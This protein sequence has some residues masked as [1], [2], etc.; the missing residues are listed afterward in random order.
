MTGRIDCFHSLKA[1][2]GGGV[3]F[4]DGNKIF[5]LS[6]GKIGKFIN[7]VIEDVYYVSGLK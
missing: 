6:V 2:Q 7:H 3:F 1:L 4:G 5:I